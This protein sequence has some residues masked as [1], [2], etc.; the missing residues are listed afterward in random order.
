MIFSAAK[1]NNA[2]EIKHFIKVSSA[3]SFECLEASLNNSFYLFIAPLLGE[4]LTET[5]IDSYTGTLVDTE[6]D[7]IKAKLL[8]LCQRAN[9]NLAFWYDFDELNT[10]I[11]DSGFQRQETEKFKPTFK[12]QEN[13]LKQNFKNKGFNALDEVLAFLEK[14]AETFPEF[15]ESETYKLLKSSIVRSTE[16]VDE[17]YF[18]NK[19]RI[20]YLRLQPHIRHACEVVLRPALGDVLYDQLCAWLA[21]STLDPETEAKAE[22]LRKACVK[23]VALEA[24]SR[25]MIETGSLTDRG[26]YFSSISPNA[27]GDES[28]QPVDIERQATQLDQVK[29][30][31]STYMTQLMK[32]VKRNFPDMYVGNPQRVYDRDNDN[33]PTFWA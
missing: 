7:K 24:V 32:Y 25:L 2:E 13:N 17:L 14:N 3:L 22:S 9:A 15:E 4:S 18:I 33:K 29:V 10:R 1:W 28:S 23:V 6:A 16:E 20:I 30:Y 31:V 19:S 11:T 8:S 27:D 12:Y 21:S 5:V 26:L